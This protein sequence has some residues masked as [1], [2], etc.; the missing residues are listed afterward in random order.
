MFVLSLKLNNPTELIIMRLRQNYRVDQKKCITFTNKNFRHF[1][2]RNYL[3]V[4]CR[5]LTARSTNEYSK[6]ALV[7]IYLL[8][9]ECGIFEVE[10]ISF[11]NGTGD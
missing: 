5:N 11:K 7:T 8:I 6:L 10:S 9:F 4:R 3:S 2:F 1:V